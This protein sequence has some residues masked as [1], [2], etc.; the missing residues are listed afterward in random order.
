MRYHKV[1]MDYRKMGKS[2][3]LEAKSPSVNDSNL[4]SQLS[5]AAIAYSFSAV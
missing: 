1:L 2:D 3:S 4:S 5:S